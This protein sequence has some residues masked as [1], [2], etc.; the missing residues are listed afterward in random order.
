MVGHDH[1]ISANVGGHAGVVGVEDAFQDQFAAPLVADAFDLVPI[2]QRVELLVRPFGQIGQIGDAFD[3]ADDVAEGAARRAQHAQ[4]PGGFGSDVDQV[5]QRQ[6]W[7]RGQ[8]VFQIL[9]AL[10]EDLQ[11]E[12]QHQRRAVGLAGALDDGIN[13][14]FV[15][16]HIELEPERRGRMFDNVFD[17]ADRHGGQGERHPERCGGAGGLD[18][19]IRVLHAGRSHRGQRHR[20][21]NRG[22]D[23]A[24][25]AAAPGQIAGNALAQADL[26]EIGGVF[27]EGLFGVAARFRVIVE[28][29]R[30]ALLVQLLEIIDAGDHRGGEGHGGGPF[31]EIGHG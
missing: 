26:G 17:R 14:I 1:R 6:F 11:I 23:H 9:V 12:R 16:H 4:R 27:T 13:E 22:A 29:L 3:V 31:V 30:R 7:R 18:L 2:Q 28:H 8:A 21:R 5:R 19:T 20:H 15:L 10:A 25:R 24:D